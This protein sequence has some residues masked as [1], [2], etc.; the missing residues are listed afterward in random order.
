VFY[1]N[2]VAITSKGKVIAGATLYKVTG[3]DRREDW[4]RINTLWAD[5]AV[6]SVTLLYFILE[7]YKYI[8]PSSDISPAAKSVLTRF[9]S[10][11]KGTEVVIEGVMEDYSGELGA[12]YVWSPKLRK[13]PVQI[14]KPNSPEELKHIKNTILLG[15]DRAYTD[16]KRTKK[17]PT[18]LLARGEVYKLYNLLEYWIL[19]GDPKKTEALTW[20]RNNADKLKENSNKYAEDVLSL[21]SQ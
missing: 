17:D 6:A 8:L 16:L 14:G 5:S 19:E 21:D 13:V 11:Y 12:G 10:K 18:S 4:Y 9:Y 20:I 15:F 1:D 3:L 2:K 7:H